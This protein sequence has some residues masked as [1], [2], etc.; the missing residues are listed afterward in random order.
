MAQRNAAQYA[1]LV[2][3]LA[4]ILETNV[5]FPQT[6]PK[7]ANGKAIREGIYIHRQ[8]LGRY[9]LQHRFRKEN[10]YV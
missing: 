2:S 8:S 1:K 7:S 3:H 5:W 10:S 6:E 9:L 4:E